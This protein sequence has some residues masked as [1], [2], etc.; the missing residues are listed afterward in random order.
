MTQ[1][2]NHLLFKACTAKGQAFMQTYARH[3]QPA[4]AADQQRRTALAEAAVA[5]IK[6]I[7]TEGLTAKLAQS[8]AAT[9]WNDLF[10]PCLGCG[11]CTFVCPTCYCFDIVDETDGTGG[12][13]RIRAWD[14]C[15]FALFT[16]HAS[17][18][19]PRPSKK[20]RM[21]QRIMHKFSYAVENQQGMLC[22]GCGR[23][24]RSCP[25]NLD[26]REM[27][28]TLRTWEEPEEF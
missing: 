5:Q 23:C 22:V 2:D 24:V 6:P 28:E 1:L 9:V 12:G 20:E 25:V 15:Q 8:F 27:I 21:R 17:G 14:A 10:A 18:H 11:V 4:T 16:L 13:Q 19:N 26:I 3:F 7:Q